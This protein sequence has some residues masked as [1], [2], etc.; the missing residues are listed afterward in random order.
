MISKHTT[1]E[2]IRYGLA[3]LSNTIISLLIYMACVKLFSAPFWAANIAAILGGLI[4][5]YF[6]SQKFVFTSSGPKLKKTAPRYAAV[7]TLQFIVTTAMI[8]A[9]ISSGYNEIPA[10][11]L[12]LPIAITL[13]FCLQKLWVFKSV[14][15]GLKT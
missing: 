12:T 10:Y 2:I 13:S 11:L 6:L 9:L 5:G 15:S 3:G 7:I 1:L 8:G 14:N 4:C